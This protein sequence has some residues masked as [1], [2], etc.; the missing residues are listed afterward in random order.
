MDSHIL[1]G[2]R[3]VDCP[4]AIL[5]VYQVI[6]EQAERRRVRAIFSNMV[7]PKIVNELLAK[8]TLGLGGARCRITVLFTDVRGFTEFTEASQKEAGER[9]VNERLSAVEAEVCFDEQ[10]S[11]A[12]H[13][14]NEYLGLVA[15]T[16]IQNDGT[17]DK[18]IGDCVMAFW[19]APTPNPRHA[20]ACVQAA[21]EIQR[22]ICAL[23][24]QRVVENAR[25]ETENLARR[26]GGLPLLPRQPILM[27]GTGI[28]TGPA[29][30][31]L[32]GSARTRQF[33]YTVFGRD[34]NLA[35][36]LEGAS[37]RGRIFISE[38]TFQ[39]VR[40]DDPRPGGHLHRATRTSPT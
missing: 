17:L 4:Y 15:D 20:L 40:R 27:L 1:A 31:G 35:S 11:R 3:G 10:A 2:I 9:V 13:T 6:F 36:R 8:P 28:N 29:T 26:S 19:G 34:V 14:V 39:E 24:R 38:A 22:A 18:F 16:I 33:S 25:R 30:A 21:I 12:L 37:G 5:L 7:S 23:N 32:M